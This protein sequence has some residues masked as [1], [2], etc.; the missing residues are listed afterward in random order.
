[1]RQ[2]GTVLERLALGVLLVGGAGMLVAMFLGT[3]DVVGT[4]FFG[5]PIHGA[6]EITESTM[7]L[8][9]F[10]ALAYAQIRRAHIRV[11]LIYTHVGPRGQAA[12]DVIGDLAALVFFGFLIWQCTGEAMLSWCIGE[13]ADG[14]LRFP[15]YPARWILVVGTGLL[16]ARLA[17]DLIHDLGRVRSGEAFE[18][19]A[20]APIAPEMPGLQNDNAERE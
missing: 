17:L 15:L 12:M 16:M 7:V 6:K 5:Q 4:Q 9:V 1:M 14:L 20:P 2:S 18:G 8:I 11:E 13:A 3:G 19:H 10:G